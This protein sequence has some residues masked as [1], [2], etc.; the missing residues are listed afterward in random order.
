[1]RVAKVRILAPTASFRYPHFLVGKQIT[2]SMPPPSTI[3][4]HVA[5]AVGQLPPPEFTRPEVAQVLIDAMRAG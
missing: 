2:Y 5:S 4:G 1:M 3:Y